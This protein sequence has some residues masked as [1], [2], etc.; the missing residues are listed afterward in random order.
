MKEYHKNVAIVLAFLKERGYSDRTVKNHEDFY[1]LL[2]DALLSE[3]SVY[4]VEYGE[5]LLSN[6][7]AVSWL[8]KN[9]FGNAACIAK[10]ND[11]YVNGC[12]DHAQASP[13]KSYSKLSLDSC[14]AESV[15]AFLLSRKD[16]FSK[17][18]IENARRRCQLFMKYIQSRG[19]QSPR[20]ITYGDVDAYHGELSC[21]KRVSRVVEESTLH[22]FLHFLNK[23]AGARYGL[24]L[25]MRALETDRSVTLEDM[26]Q[27]EQAVITQKGTGASLLSAE[28]YL[29]LG[30]ELIKLHGK[31]GYVGKHTEASRRA[32]LQLYLFLDYHGLG[33]DPDMSDIWINSSCVRERVFSDGPWQTARHILS[34]FADYAKSGT[35]NFGKT[36][37]RGISGLAG[38]PD[39]CAAPLLG[40]AESRRRMKLNE[41]TVKNDIY[42]ILRFC[43]FIVSEGLSS[44]GEV[45][46]Q[47]LAEFNLVDRHGSPEGKN[48]CNSRIKRFLRYLCREDLASPPS[49]YMALGYSAAPVET[50][51][52]VLTR[53]ET[54]E[55]K[56]FLSNASTRLE[57][58]DSAVMMLGLEMGM[59]SSDIAGLKLRDIDWKNR[60]ILFRQ[61]KTDTDVWIPMPVAVGNAVFRYLSQSRPRETKSQNVFVDFRA[62]FG[63]LGRGICYGALKRVL[64]HRDV[65]GSGFHVTRKT[66]STNRL[67]NGVRPESIADAIGHRGT[68]SLAHYLSLDDERMAEC[69]LSLADL[70]LGMEGGHGYDRN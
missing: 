20:E 42:S 69:P 70:C 27:D 21:L 40:F 28:A 36:I 48:S 46:A 57:I 34:V 2:A 56:I 31:A 18:Q 44:Y 7:A 37:Q 11:V 45:D 49:L 41:E 13:R 58:R 53:E 50:V 30:L 43:K 54:D 62:P 15:S 22:Q 33:Y 19:R 16:D 60:A 65:R 61:G 3:G 32:I 8:P 17:A 23:T 51:V 14:F 24:C 39:W 55:V 9:R 35:A 4:S 6:S 26:S 64:P 1:E 12:I 68:E 66:F 67:R 47:H 52:V 5:S 29:S 59:R 25:R 63:A 38:L 10:L